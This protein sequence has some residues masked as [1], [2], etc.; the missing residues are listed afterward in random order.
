MSPPYKTENNKDEEEITGTM[1]TVSLTNKLTNK[2][3]D[4][5][6]LCI[7]LRTHFWLILIMG[8]VRFKELLI[9]VDTCQA[10]T[11]F[12]QVSLILYFTI[13]E[14]SHAL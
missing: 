10:S 2:D 1:L 3:S 11:L 6:F 5:L 7:G 9:M 12:S 8:F 14:N 13:L 4:L